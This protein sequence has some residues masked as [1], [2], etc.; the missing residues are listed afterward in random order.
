M[1]AVGCL[2]LALFGFPRPVFDDMAEDERQ[3]GR[4]RGVRRVG[5]LVRFIKTV[6]EGGNRP[7]P[8]LRGFGE[9]GGSAGSSSKP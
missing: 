1:F 9:F 5:K 8:P 6:A 4:R 2:L 7:L 3:K